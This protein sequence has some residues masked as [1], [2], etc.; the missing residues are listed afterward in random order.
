MKYT[1]FRAHLISFRY[2]YFTLGLCGILVAALANSPAPTQAALTSSNP[3]YFGVLERADCSSIAGFAYD[4][5]DPNATVS[6]DI[7]ADGNYV[8]TV[9]RIGSDQS[10]PMRDGR[11]RFMDF[12]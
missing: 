7:F 10:C 11:I 2:L 9:P 8:I 5:N 12:C 6:V 1:K 3:S 4:E